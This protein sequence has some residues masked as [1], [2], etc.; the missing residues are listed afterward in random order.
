MMPPV[1]EPELIRLVA[2]DELDE[3]GVTSV[4]TP[5]GRLAVGIAKGEPFAVSDRCRHLLV[6][7]GGKGHVTEEGCLEC[8]AHG[9]RYDVRTGQMVRGPGKI[10]TPVGGLVKSGANAA[11]PLKRYPVIERDGV[12]YLESS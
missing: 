8:H 1:A 10:F 6:S 4:K 2:R 3:R 12:L 11:A 5:H 7:L 9:A